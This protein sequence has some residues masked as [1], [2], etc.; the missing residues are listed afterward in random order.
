MSSASAQCTSTSASPS[1]C[2]PSSMR[3]TRPLPGQHRLGQLEHVVARHVEHGGFDLGEASVH[4]P[5]AAGPASGSPGARPAGCLPPGRQ[6]T[7]GCAGPPRPPPRAGPGRPGAGQSTAA[8]GRARWGRSGPRRRCPPARQT[9]RRSWWRLIGAPTDIGAGARGAA[10]APRPLRVAGLQA[11]LEGTACRCCDRGNLTA[12]PTPGCPRWTATAT[13][14]RWCSG[15][16]WCT[17][18]CMP[19]CSRATC[20]SCWAATTA[21]ASAA[22]APWRAT[23]A[24]RQKAARAVAGRPCRLQHQR[25]HAQRQ[26][27]RH[28]GG[29]PV[30]LWPAELTQ[31]ASMP[32]GVPALQP[33]A[34]APDRHPQRGRGR[35]ALCARAGLEVFD[36]RYIDEMGMRHTMELA[37]AT[38]DANTHLHVSFRRRLPRP[39]HRPRRG[40]H[41]ARRPHLPRGAAV[42]GDDCRH[43]PPGLARRVELNPA[44]DVRNKTAVLAVDLVESLFGKSTLMRSTAT[45]TSPS[46]VRLC[47]LTP[48]R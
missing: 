48:P 43:R 33:R 6:K 29:L 4:P 11:A 7:A 47:M 10:W 32:G 40:H 18:P 36:M 27:A 9:R 22:S 39:R 46:K 17:A 13:C 15:T 3:C 1:A 38:L 2:R 31:L 24:R 44:L 5:G 20:P 30:R 14:P 45:G 26:C 19:S 8:A 21:W 28:A 35:K 41:R 25:A 12:R 34:D 42:H 23:A 16:G 37:L